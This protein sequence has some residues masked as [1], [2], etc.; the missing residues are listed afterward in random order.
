[1][2]MMATAK[3]APRKM[4]EAFK[5][6]FWH[7]SS[8]NRTSWAQDKEGAVDD[9][10]LGFE[11][12]KQIARAG[13]IA[14]RAETSAAEGQPAPDPLVHRMDGTEARLVSGHAAAGRPLVLN[15]GSCT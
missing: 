10:N 15:F 6:N 12:V 3:L 13:M 7:G 9:A 14:H 5:A 2:A 4:K 11:M 8:M 1:M